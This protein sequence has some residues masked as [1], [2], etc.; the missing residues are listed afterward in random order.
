MFIKIY[1]FTVSVVSLFYTI[2]CHTCIT[3]IIIII[4]LIL[5]AYCI[6]VL[7]ILNILTL[8]EPSYAL[9][10]TTCHPKAVGEVC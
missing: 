3:C 9:L 8:V 4:C 10:P 6:C 1:T 2:T 7:C 5:H